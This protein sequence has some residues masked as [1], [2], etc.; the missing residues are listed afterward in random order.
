ME[1]QGHTVIAWYFAIINLVA[2]LTY[3]WDK[4]RQMSR[5]ACA[6]GDA[7][8]FCRCRWKHWSTGSNENFSP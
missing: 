1:N 6:G 4:V 5:M 3:G 8:R 2:F 7:P